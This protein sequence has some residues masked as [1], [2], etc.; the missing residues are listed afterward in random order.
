MA[1]SG[2]KG[3]VFLDGILKVKPAILRTGGA[4]GGYLM[5]PL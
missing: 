5:A 3:N 1:A 2:G 4:K